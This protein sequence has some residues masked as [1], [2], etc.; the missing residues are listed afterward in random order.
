MAI[1]KTAAAGFLWIVFA[2]GTIL[3]LTTAKFTANQQIED[4]STT[5]ESTRASNNPDSLCS[6][7]IKEVQASGQF[8]VLHD[9]R[10]YWVESH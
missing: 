8:E 4:M 6:K 5:C 10:H 2:L 1:S 9:S 7:L 3:G